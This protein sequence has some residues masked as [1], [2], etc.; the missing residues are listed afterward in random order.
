M[1]VEQASVCKVVAVACALALA[2]CARG[3]DE[4]AATAAAATAEA[5]VQQMAQAAEAQVRE[6]EQQQVA[7]A[8]SADREPLLKLF[9]P[10]FRMVN[11]SGGIV[12]REEL[13]GLLT[14]A[15]P[16]SEATYT[17]D[18]V[19]AHEDVVVTIG[20]EQVTFGGGAQAGQKQQRR[21]TQVWERNGEGGWHLVQRH[22]TLV[23]P[24][25]P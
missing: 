7:V 23:A 9:A 11:P 10:D 4:Q 3:T 15:R 5:Y 2:G 8:L 20:T 1:T 19:R 14:G 24:P 18:S 13:L 6:L 25:A 21:I 17:T 16:Y 12:A 22:A